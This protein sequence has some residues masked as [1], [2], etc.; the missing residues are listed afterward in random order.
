M[1]SIP[2]F[3]LVRAYSALFGPLIAETPATIWVEGENPVKSSMH[4]H[5]WYDQVKKNVLSGGDWISNFGP[6]PGEATYEFEAPATGDYKFW[7]RANPL[8][9]GLTYVLDGDAVMPVNLLYD[10]RGEQNIASD[11]KPDLRFIAWVNAG[12]LTLA[13]GKHTLT[14]RIAGGK[15]NHGAIDCFVLTTGPF[16]PQGT[17]KPGEPR[18]GDTADAGLKDAIW[19]EG[20]NPASSTMTRHPWWYD[21]VK[22]DALSSGDWISNF[23]KDK[24]G[25]A[26]YNFEAITPDTYAFWIRANP[27]A[28]AKLSWRLDGGVW[29]PVDFAD[30]RGIQ[31]IAA[32]NKP[33][34]RFIAWVKGGNVRLATGR[35]AIRFRMD[36]GAAASNHGGLD[37]F[38]FTRIPFVPSGATKPAVAKSVGGPGDWFPLLADDDTFDP[39]SVIDMSA[40][41][42][43]PA[44]KFGFLHAAGKD[45]CFERADAPVKLWGCGANIEPGRYSRVQLIQRARYLRKFG[46][47]AVR[48]HAVF[49]ELNTNGKIDPQKLDQYDWWFAELKK[50]GIYTDWS[51]FYNFTIGPDDGYDPSLFRDLEGGAERKSTYGIITIAPAL[52]DIRNKTLVALLTHRNPY[53]GLRYTEDPALAVV[54]MQ[55]ED[56]VFFWNPLGA[57]AEPHPKKWPLHARQLRAMFAAWIRAKYKSDDALKAAWG[58]L[59]EGDSVNAKELRLMTPWELDGAGPRGAFAGQPKRAGD[60]IEFLTGLQRGEFAACEKAMRSAGFKGVTMTTAWQVG[61]AATEAANIYTDTVGG[62]ID[63]HNYAGGGEGVHSITEGKVNNESHLGR[64]GGGIFSIG[65][66]QVES[67]P[68]SVTEWTQSAPNQWKIECAP[69]MAFYGL[70]LQG[71]DASYHFIQS[72]TRLGDGWPAMS[73]YATD[74]PAYIGQFPALAFALYRGHITESPVIAARR[75]SMADLFTGRDALKQDSTKGGYDVKS[76]IVNGGTP[77]EA[78]AIGRVTVDFAGGRTEQANFAK[79]WDQ[80]NK[81]IRSV[82]G[83]LTWDYGRQ[84]VTVQTQ[85]TQAVIGRTGAGL[86]KLPG[87]TVQFVTPFVSMIF[88]PLDDLPLARSG[89]ILITALARDKQAGSRYSGDGTRL[90]ATGTAPLL[91]EPVQATIRLAGT[92]PLRVTPCDHYGVPMAGKSVPVDADGTFA[93][94]GTY[95]AYY[96]AVSR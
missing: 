21:Q 74:T 28:G 64:P 43:A 39:R 65:M 57:L 30:A 15:E 89:R 62:M 82:T 58:S 86:F 41:V 56:S 78:F 49:D 27:S 91:L 76:M 87:V 77:L 7:I 16:V 63:R 52:W 54:E 94:N 9:A 48:Q 84:V 47:N 85:K 6:V 29:T 60:C 90:E 73:S 37:C 38:V 35:H 53:T 61:G 31:N 20:E 22:K 33:D 34:M 17:L 80:G 71:W 92:R 11:H 25:E 45:L 24:P 32:D 75:L 79:Y 26:E 5:P 40:L 8:G 96:Y 51:V 67:K 55:N 72:G 10:K 68:F 12:H 69:L 42:P 44:G 93:I 3:A 88:T 66:K 18:A 95:R 83:E 59:R 1:K 13:R 50:N 81:M 70:G 46:V 14:F 36:S 4:R 2:L 23:N 19:I